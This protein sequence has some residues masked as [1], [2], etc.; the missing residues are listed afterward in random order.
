[1]EI[2]TCATCKHHICVMKTPSNMGHYCK[3]DKQEKYIKEPFGHT[4]EN[5][6]KDKYSE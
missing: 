1:M 5:Y 6:E 2:K 3:C 4:C